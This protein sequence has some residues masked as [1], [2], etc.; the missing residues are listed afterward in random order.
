MTFKNDT[1]PERRLK[2]DG[3]L[4]THDSAFLVR[5]DQLVAVENFRGEGGSLQL[6]DAA[7][8]LVTVSTA[9]ATVRPQIPT[10]ID[11]G[12]GS[13]P[14]ATYTCKYFL[15]RWGSS[16]TNGDIG[17]STDSAGLVLGA[18]RSIE[19]RI[20]AENLGEGAGQVYNIT[21]NELGYDDPFMGGASSTQVAV[22][23][24]S[25]A[26]N[27]EFQGLQS[28]TWSGTYWTKTLTTFTTGLATNPSDKD[29]Y[30][31]IRKLMAYDIAK[32]GI[33]IFGNQAA[34]FTLA[35]ATYPPS[36]ASIIVFG[37]DND[38]DTLVYRPFSHQPTPIDNAVVSR[39][40]VATDGVKPKKL[41]TASLGTGS[42]PRWRM[43]G[44]NPPD[45]APTMALAGAGVPNGTYSYRMTFIYKH[46]R[47]KGV[48]GNESWYSESRPTTSAATVA[49]VNQQVTVTFNALRGDSSLY[50]IRLYRT[51][52]GGSTYKRLA[53]IDPASTTYTDNIADGS[54]GSKTDPDD[55]GKVTLDTPPTT[56]ILVRR[57]GN[58]CIGIV[59]VHDT[60]QT[61]Q[62]VMSVRGTNQLRLSRPQAETYADPNGSDNDDCEFTVDHWPNDVDHTLVCGGEGDSNCLI[63]YRGVYY[64]FKDAEIGVVTGSQPGQLRYD[65]VYEKIGAIRDSAISVE[66]MMYFWSASRGAYAFDGRGFRWIGREIIDTWLTDRDQEQ[67]YYCRDVWFDPD[68]N[69]I[70]WTFTNAALN[71]ATAQLTSNQSNIATVRGT[72]KEYAYNIDQQAWWI[73]SGASQTRDVRAAMTAVIG[74]YGAPM[75]GR[76]R[77][78]LGTSIGTLC[79]DHEPTTNI[80]RDPTDASSGQTITAT[81][82]LKVH[83]LNEDWSFVKKH[84]YLFVAYTTG[85][86]SSGSLVVAGKANESANFVTIGTISTTAVGLKTAFLRIPA[87]IGDNI[88]MDR[89]IQIKFTSTLNAALSI[90]AAELRYRPDT[91]V[92]ATVRP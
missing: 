21:D 12:A 64:L 72:F 36:S 1:T 66:G 59:G 70:K 74:S 56:L 87:A 34:S 5:P 45:A 8:F 37:H 51:V 76:T 57:L 69:E 10:L 42:N 23:L 47:Q 68:T 48:S 32:Q 13:I 91:P 31:P 50:K 20:P 82:T 89:G 25:G 84:V 61:S 71:P 15:T 63:D 75:S 27:W 22:Y 44:A 9:V 4:N 16:S 35:G 73:D 26:G 24:R 38:S 55:E 80:Y 79:M 29:S 83:G 85:T 46:T 33:I 92:K 54:L 52:A 7:R 60:T 30:L 81:A 14:A 49:P 53:D 41:H 11:A 62:R 78:I 19:I 17:A 28:F 39:V 58:R 65:V 3:G 86:V 40:L 43:L 6:R 88:N 90:Q 18:N 77:V 67:G 2:L